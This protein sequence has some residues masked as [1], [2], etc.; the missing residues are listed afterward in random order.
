VSD[1]DEPLIF[2]LSDL[3]VKRALISRIGTLQGLWEV[4]LK[5]RKRT[6]TLDQ[7]AY[8]FAAIATPF[9]EWLREQYGDSQI[10][11][12][13]A[14]EMLKVKILGMDEKL[15]E[16][17]DEVLRLIP[18]S[19]TLDTAEFAEYIFKCSAW[20]ESFCGIVIIPSDLFYEGATKPKP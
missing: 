5:Q 11:T 15:I 9:R 7:N 13:Q 6:R 20:L 16:G 14:H 19:K 4:R 1:I 12:D 10:T 8:Y 18:R 17:T 2:N 3:S